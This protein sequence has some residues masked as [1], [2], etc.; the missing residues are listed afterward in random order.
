MAGSIIAT[1]GFNVTKNIVLEIKD[2]GGFVAIVPEGIIKT[3]D[4]AKETIK[5]IEFK[6]KTN[7][8]KNF[9]ITTTNDG[10][11]FV[12]GLIND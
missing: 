10:L 7:S 2:A 4:V 12:K 5:N 1:V 8:L 6:E 9:L 3:I 11:I